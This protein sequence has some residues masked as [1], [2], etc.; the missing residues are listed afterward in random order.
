MSLRSK[1]LIF[2][3]SFTIILGVI[4]TVT[5]QK[6]VSRILETE[7][8]KREIYFNKHL[9][10]MIA[11][12]VLTAKNIK[13]Q[14]ILHDAKRGSD[15][16]YFFVQNKNGRVIA[17]TFEADFPVDLIQAN[18]LGVN[19]KYN[20]Q[21]LSIGDKEIFD[22]ATPILTFG[23]LRTGILKE[24][25]KRNV[26]KII[27]ILAFSS[28]G[29]ILL[30]MIIS[31]FATIRITNPINKLIKATRAAGSGNLEYPIEINRK[32]EFGQLASAFSE[33][34]KSLRESEKRLKKT[35]NDLQ[36]EINERIKA[37]YELRENEIR[38]QELSEATFEGIAITQDGI[39][40][41]FNTRLAEMFGYDVSEM[42][43]KEIFQLLS[44]QS[45]EKTMSH[46]KLGSTGHLEPQGKKKD[47]TI[48]PIEVQIRIA[49]YKGKTARIIAI[50]DITQQKESREK[51][52][53]SL[54]EKEVLLREIHHR[55]K[56]NMQVISSLLSLQAKQFKDE[57]YTQM[58]TESKNR[59]KSMM[60][61]HEKLY[62]Y[63]DMARIDFN[64][65]IKNLINDLF[66][67]YGINKSRIKVTTDIDASLALDEGV[68][69][70]LIINEIITNSIKHAF[71]KD[72]SGEIKIVFKELKSN[73]QRK[74]NLVIS[75]NG[76]GIEK[77]ID[78]DNSD[79]LGLYLVSSLIRN[80]LMGTYQLNRENGT[81]F[82]IQFEVQNVPGSA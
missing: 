13:V 9:S 32:D 55:V 33:M 49:R 78:S 7:I 63:K 41:D 1:V 57:K 50:R 5:V 21:T 68:T 37:E 23:T 8:L 14:S 29:A 45:R 54:R 73:G 81:E 30:I 34:T 53:A 36:K 51:I 26:P 59:I 31:I 15:V 10:M 11:N 4:G 27:N 80:Q 40:I 43:E 71:G 72:R 38:L 20:I 61:I 82:N 16:E 60:L 22:I 65:Y 12:S 58:L 79:T 77:N 70:G 56:N 42:N 25:I 19:N 47:G 6:V 48:F 67:S 75:D 35:I 66:N 44:P 76:A 62:K 39:L 24:T 18:S 17:H 46:I 2:I 52:K 28:L 69:C 74:F 64:E 3:I